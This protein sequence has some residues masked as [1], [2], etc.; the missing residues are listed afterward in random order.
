MGENELDAALID[1]LPDHLLEAE[2]EQKEE[3]E[4]PLGDQV[5]D[6]NGQSYEQ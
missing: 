2:F 1:V 4:Q 3:E 6:K 5:L